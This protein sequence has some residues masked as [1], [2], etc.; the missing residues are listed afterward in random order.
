MKKNTMSN[1]IKTYIM[2]A[3]PAMFFFFAIVIIPFIYGVYLTFT[4]W[5]GISEKKELIGITNFLA[6]FQDKKFW[7]ALLLTLAYVTIST[8]LVQVIAF[9]LAYIL[10]SGLKGQNFFRAGFFTPNLIGGI[11]LGFIWQFVFSKA[12]TAFGDM[13]SI[14]L[15]T[16]SWLSDPIKAFFAL[17]LVTVWQY[18]GYMMLIYVAGFVGVPK[19]LIEAASIDGCT[20]TQRTRHIVIPMMAQSFSI[21]TF[22][23]LT[24]CF[25][26]Y[27][28]NVS[29]TGGEPYGSTI[30]AALHV[31]QKAFKSKQYGLGQAE[32]LVLFVVVAVVAVTQYYLS[33]KKEVEA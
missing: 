28:L 20:N 8:I 7:V 15:F 5:D 33:K 6:V 25:M 10:T 30:L 13:T 21:C 4:N 17:V 3:G 19:D 32:A 11:V 9:L 27:D 18:S 2:F 26:V 31:Y 1:K 24:R 29:L 23:T 22:L 12:F 16:R 14:P